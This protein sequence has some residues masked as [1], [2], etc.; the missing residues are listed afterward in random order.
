MARVPFGADQTATAVHVYNELLQRHVPAQ[1]LVRGAVLRSRVESL[2]SEGR[3]YRKPTSYLAYVER[4]WQEVLK[5]QPDGFHRYDLE[6]HSLLKR[7]ESG[8]PRRRAAAHLVIPQAQ[9]L[10]AEFFPVLRRLG[11][12]ATVFVD[13]DALV[14]EGQAT[15]EE[16]VEY[17]GSHMSVMGNREIVVPNGVVQVLERIGN[18]RVDISRVAPDVSASPVLVDHLSHRDEARFVANYASYHPQDTVGLFLPSLDLV[19]RFRRSLTEL[20]VGG[21]QWYL[22][23]HDVPARQR[24]RFRTCGVKI[25]TWQSGAGT[26][27]DRVILAGLHYAPE[28]TIQHY[29]RAL[30]ATARRELVLSYSGQGEPVY[31]SSLPLDLLNDRRGRC[32]PF[33]WSV[34]S[35]ETVKNEITVVQAETELGRQFDRKATEAA[36]RAVMMTDR[37][38]P[39]RRM[40]VLTAEQEIG[41]AYLIRGDQIPISAELP[42][43]YRATLP[44]AD[45]RA[46][47]FDTFVMHNQG[48]VRQ[49]SKRIIGSSFDNDDLHHYGLFGLYRAIEKFDAGLGNKFSTYA[50]NWINQ[51]LQRAVAD[52]DQLI[53]L[54]VHVREHVNRI[55][56]VERKLASAQMLITTEAISLH[57]GLS[58]AKVD[59]YRRLSQAVVSLDLR[60]GT[61]ETDYT[62]LGDYVAVSADL[63][64]DPDTVF[65]REATAELVESALRSLPEREALILRLRHG[66]DEE[67][68]LTLDAIGHRLGLTRE[69]I[70][71]IE[72]KGKE[73]LKDRLASLE[74]LDSFKAASKPALRVTAR[75]RSEVSSSGHKDVHQLG[76]G[77]GLAGLVQM[78]GKAQISEA[79]FLLVEQV[80]E[81]G[82]REV[83][84]KTDV[85]RTTN[86]IAIVH[87]GSF[88]ASATLIAG[89]V[90]Q[91]STDSL[92]YRGLF[93]AALLSDSV[94]VWEATTSPVCTV[95]TSSSDTGA[96][97]LVSTAAERPASLFATSAARGPGSAVLWAV[98]RVS[99]RATGLIDLQTSLH[100]ELGLVFGD[101]IRRRQLS[102]RINGTTIAPVDPFARDSSKG[103]DLGTERVRSGGYTATVTPFV[104]PH[105]NDAAADDHR[106]HEPVDGQGFYIR[107]A[108]RLVSRGGWLGIEELPSLNETT[109]ARIEVEIPYEQLRSWRRDFDEPV[110]PP[111]PLRRRLTQLAMIARKRSMLV[112]NEDQEGNQ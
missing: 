96:W 87:D 7:L 8:H 72:T 103:Q 60:V 85:G 63:V 90:R 2:F 19:N 5:D 67:E 108:G 70:R 47:A 25:L 57:T 71:Q 83:L 98:S 64:H 104:L 56:A 22:S 74:D 39:D 4:L 77:T 42:K 21:F 68:E 78:W 88:S 20:G 82:A 61:G 26:L 30:G 17:L 109:L 95:L 12:P 65:D 73:R 51:R 34:S 33:S 27:F 97:R 75:P 102:I 23:G 11:I 44:D 16:I 18:E 41:L 107:C 62:L 53:R 101:L 10:D 58:A 46:A 54:P 94:T 35:V 37:V 105:P 1:M 9:F 43:D 29:V 66:F 32:A 40:T 112:F 24:V 28:A 31:L 89:L 79:V 100:T 84:I 110:S 52:F 106:R 13:P 55:R 91:S 49:L 81:D 48:L 3:I 93:S 14:G 99:S 86:G 36:A 6:L 76:Q 80:V 15:S 45:E 69:R 111:G 59:E 50:T 92:G 38:H